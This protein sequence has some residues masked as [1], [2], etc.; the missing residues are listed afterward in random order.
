MVV[1]PWGAILLEADEAAGLYTCE[2]DLEAVT[3]IR[4]KLT[5]T[6]DRKLGVDKPS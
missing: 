3:R 6:R 4:S 1:D 2:I 5:A